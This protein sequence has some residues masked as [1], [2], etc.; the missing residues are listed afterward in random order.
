VGWMSEHSTPS[1]SAIAAW[2]AVVVSW[3]MRALAIFVLLAALRMGQDFALAVA[4]VCAASAASVLPIAP[5]GAA[6][7]AGAGAA[8]LV[9]A[10]MHSGEAIA[11]GIAAQGLIVGVGAIYLGVVAVAHAG[12]RLRPALALR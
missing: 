8:I 2:A 11:F 7:Q 12:A 5:A 9:A 3:T 4:F 6:M 1:R 10:G